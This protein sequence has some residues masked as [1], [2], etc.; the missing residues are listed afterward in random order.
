VCGGPARGERFAQIVRGAAICLGA[1]AVPESA[2]ERGGG[3]SNRMWKVLGCGGFFLGPYVEGIEQFARDGEHCAWYRDRD[4]AVELVRHYLA[5]PAARARIGLAGRAH[6]LR[7]HTYAQRIA[8]L[9]EGRGY[10]S[11]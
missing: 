1:H 10:T 5:D 9:L 3:A 11:T 7:H 8:L 6:A 4:H 2:Q